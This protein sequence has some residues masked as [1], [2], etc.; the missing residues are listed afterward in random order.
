M[1]QGA[2]IVRNMTFFR[3]RWYGNVEEM[4]NQNM[5]KKFATATEDETRE[6]GRA[7]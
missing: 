1:L 4:Q 3:Q 5:P 7:S 2:D 6:S